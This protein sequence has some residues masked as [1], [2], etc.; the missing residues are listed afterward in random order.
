MLVTTFAQWRSVVFMLSVLVAGPALATDGPS[1]DVQIRGACPAA[2]V[3]LKNYGAKHEAALKHASKQTP[4]EPALRTRLLALAARDQEARNRI[5]AEGQ[6]YS[7]ASLKNVL[8]VDAADLVELRAIIKQFGFPTRA[9]VG[10]DG[11]RAAFILVQHADTDRALQASVLKHVLGS[12]SEL[13]D[14]DEA[15][16][17]FDRV[18][19]A[20]GKPQRY[21]SQLAMTNGKLTPRLPV[22]DISTIDARRTSVGLMPLADYVCMVNALQP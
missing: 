15:A 13:M 21:G 5:D 1:L 7:Q 11:V 2:S 4:G 22:E 14:P 8:S 12:G 19:L 9:Q 10:D 3:W 20:S 6:N 16:M 18:A 17:L